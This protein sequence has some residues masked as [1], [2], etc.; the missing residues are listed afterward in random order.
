MSELIALA[1]NTLGVLLDDTGR[2]HEALP[3][4]EEAVAIR[5]QL[6]GE[7]SAFTAASLH[8]L[9]VALINTGRLHE[10]AGVLA[11]AIDIR[12]EVH[13]KE[14]P[15]TVETQVELGRAF[16]AKGDLL[17]AELVLREAETILDRASANGSV[18]RILA[19]DALAR[20]LLDCGD[21]AD[22]LPLASLAVQLSERA[23]GPSHALTAAMRAT[24]ALVLLRL[25][26]TS[27]S[28]S[29]AF[30]VMELLNATEAQPWCIDC[31]YDAWDVVL[32][33]QGPAAP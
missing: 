31:V 20:L 21:A 17:R 7:R 9:G 27:E 16:K 3:L 1:V 4:L 24:L 2:A 22:A 10:G 28:E 23:R 15:W 6:N 12:C 19:K 18:V 5:K 29:C 25:N 8:N 26:R 14:H 30:Q 13:G 32:W 33:G 11:E